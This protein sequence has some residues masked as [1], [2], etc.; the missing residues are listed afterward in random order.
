MTPLAF[1][2]AHRFVRAKLC[3][4]F[5]AVGWHS[6]RMRL[7]PLPGGSYRFLTIGLGPLRLQFVNQASRWRD[8][9]PEGAG[10]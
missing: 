6:C 5:W 3:W 4:R 8:R 9:T 2:R 7:S 10:Q 1:V